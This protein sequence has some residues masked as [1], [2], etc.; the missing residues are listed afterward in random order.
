[1]LQHVWVLLSSLLQISMVQFPQL[2]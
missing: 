2:L 1:V